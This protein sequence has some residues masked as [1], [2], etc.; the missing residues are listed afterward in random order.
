M[1]TSA[2]YGA[3][4]TRQASRVDFNPGGKVPQRNHLRS[5][6]DPKRTICCK[7]WREPWASPWRA[8]LLQVWR[9][10]PSLQRDGC[11]RKRSRMT[12]MVGGPSVLRS[13]ARRQGALGPRGRRKSCGT[14]FIMQRMHGD[15]AACGGAS[16]TKGRAASAALRAGAAISAA[17]CESACSLAAAELHI[18]EYCDAVAPHCS[19]Y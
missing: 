13:T 16:T 4:H 15:R 18:T 10:L 5:W 17:G 9:L 19:G 14:T 2:A 8:H 6:G 12:R 3:A 11:Q 7:V 1:S